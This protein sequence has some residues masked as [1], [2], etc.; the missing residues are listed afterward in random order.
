MSLTKFTSGRSPWLL[1]AYAFIAIVLLAFIGYLIVYFIYA[2]ALFQFPFDYDQGE[3]F[4]LVDTLMFSRGEWPSLPH[5][6]DQFTGRFLCK[7]QT[8]AHRRQFQRL[9][10]RDITGIRKKVRRP[11]NGSDQD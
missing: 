1:L 3:G 5:P 11:D 4:E 8:V 6:A 2:F 9:P 7:Q 10:G